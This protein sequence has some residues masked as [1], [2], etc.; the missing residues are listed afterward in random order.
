MPKFQNK[1]VLFDTRN[2]LTGNITNV[3]TDDQI[4]LDVTQGYKNKINHSR[5][6]PSIEL[7]ATKTILEN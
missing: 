3:N 5:S 1:N 4:N 2:C 7:T 6:Y